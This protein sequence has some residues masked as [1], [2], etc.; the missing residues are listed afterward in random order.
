MGNKRGE[1]SNESDERLGSEGGS[2]GGENLGFP[3][4]ESNLMYEVRAELFT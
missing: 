1:H 3:E 4:I 2:E